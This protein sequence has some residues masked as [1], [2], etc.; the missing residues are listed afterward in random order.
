MD[1]PDDHANINNQKLE[2]Q[3]IKFQNSVFGGQ[4]YCLKINACKYDL[5]MEKTLVVSCFT[6]SVGYG[7][8]L[9]LYIICVSCLWKK[10]KSRGRI[11]FCHLAYI[12]VLILLQ[13]SFV[14]SYIRTVEDM[15]V[16]NRYYP[17]GPM[18]YF[19]ATQNLAEDVVFI[20]SLFFATF[21]SDLLMFWR[22]WV[23]WRSSENVISH[24][25]VFF[26]VLSIISSL[27]LG[28][29]WT[30]QSSQRGL[31][32][33]SKGPIA[34]GTAYYV[35]SLSINVF[36]TALIILRLLLHRRAILNLLPTACTS[37]YLSLTAII[38]ESALLYSVFALIFIITYAINNPINQVFLS[39]CTTCQQIAGHLIIVRVAQGRAWNS[40][41][42]IN[43]TMPELFADT[44]VRSNTPIPAGDIESLHGHSSIMTNTSEKSKDSS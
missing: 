16:N 35:V 21:L 37:Q 14:A 31:S 39:I 38:I 12:T 30:T 27:A 3:P 41:M 24:V 28:T 34:F 32:M 6:A 17:G 29:V 1:K 20:V 33:F 44:L 8:Q 9:V 19:F 2:V 25:V 26:P 15:Y 10:L 5:S 4:G 18:A 43:A 11:I 7:V 42:S 40:D 23:I 22:C 36:V 13:S